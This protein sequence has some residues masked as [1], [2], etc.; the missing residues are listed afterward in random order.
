MGQYIF[1]F[2]A[3]VPK[4]TYEALETYV[5]ATPMGRMN[6]RR[7]IGTTVT[8]TL[9]HDS[10]RV[11]LYG[12]TLAVLRSHQVAF[13][14]TDDPHMST[15]AWLSKIIRD[16]GIGGLAWRIRRHASDGEGPC[17]PRGHAGLL[18]IDGDRNRPVFGNTYPTRI[19]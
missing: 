15:S 11:R 18:T 6:V 5:L 19:R 16:N 4:L 9:E 10:A 8:V 12:Y 14:S 7:D 1:R 2:P 17:V 13:N 3:G